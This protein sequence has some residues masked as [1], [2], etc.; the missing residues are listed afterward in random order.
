MKKFCLFLFAAAATAISFAGR[1]EAEYFLLKGNDDSRALEIAK[2]YLFS[3]GKNDLTVYDIS[4]PLH[5]IFKAVLK[6]IGTARQMIHNGD[7]LYITQRE[8]GIKIIDIKNPLKPKNA[9]FYDT[10]EMATGI[11]TAGN[12]LFCAQRI[13]GVETLDISDPVHPRPVSLQRT[14]EAQSCIYRNGLLYVGD[15]GTS[16]LT[17]IDMKNPAK[18]RIIT[19]KPLDGFGDGVDISNGYCYAATGHHSRNKDKS[20]RFGSGHGLEIF[21]LANPASPEKISVIKFPK[22]H[23]TGNDYWSVRV[24]GDTA[25]VADTH[26]GVFAVDVK[27]KKNPFIRQRI[28]F[29]EVKIKDRKLPACVSDIELGKNAVYAAVQNIGLAVI[30]LQGVNFSAP[31]PTE[32]IAIRPDR[33]KNW[34]NYKCYDFNASVRRVAVNKDTAYIACSVAGLKVL[35]LNSGKV[36]QSVSVPCAYDVAVDK[37]KLYCAAGWNGIIVYEIKQDGRIAETF[38]RSKFVFPNRKKARAVN[39][40]MLMKPSTGKLLAFSDRSAWI[41]FAD[42]TRGL[43]VV[44]REQWTRLL[45]GDAMPDNDINGILPVHYCNFGTLWFDVKGDRAVVVARNADLKNVSGQSEGWSIFDG[46]FLAP[47][48]KGFTL[49]EAD[50]PGNVRAFTAGSFA[51]GTATAN[52]SVVA[53]ANRAKGTVKVIDL[54]NPET[55]TELKE[56]SLKL[57]GTPDRVRFWKNHLLIPAGLDGL[58][59][60]NQPVK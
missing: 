53:F 16:Y 49:L 32:K 46:K 24:S 55:P 57:N 47:S 37:N 18:P 42:T 31:R 36:I 54:K 48:R 1:T 41:C 56:F 30:P 60:S 5:P 13:Y 21:S 8:S 43:D 14:D 34:K 20:K 45:Y 15:W 19:R 4:D 22:F 11:D 39:I 59:V 51:S 40:Q 28:I 33:A 10:V 3:A 17:V 23:I 9:G 7:Y 25:V 26:N 12:L 38:R 27:D 52:G 29:P 58:L 6:N 44:T 50:S 2:G 35:D